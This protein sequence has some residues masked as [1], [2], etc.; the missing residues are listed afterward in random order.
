LILN[1]F[2]IATSLR[3]SQ[4]R[5][6]QRFLSKKTR[7]TGEGRY[8]DNQNNATKWDITLVLSALRTFFNAGFPPAR[9]RRVNGLFWANWIATRHTLFAAK[10]CSR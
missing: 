6:N 9:E 3:S 10:G 4:R 7:H 8:P 5:F 2:W 1:K